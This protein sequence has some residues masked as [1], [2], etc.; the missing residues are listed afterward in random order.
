MINTQSNLKTE[1]DK[2]MTHLKLRHTLLETYDIL[3]Y[4]D[5]IIVKDIK[6]DNFNKLLQS[7]FD[8]IDLLPDYWDE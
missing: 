4:K 8:Q 6:P 2:V 1:F 3:L 5:E 7:V